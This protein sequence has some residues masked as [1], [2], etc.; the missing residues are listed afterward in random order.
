MK[1]QRILLIFMGN[2]GLIGILNQTLKQKLSNNISIS[3]KCL[4]SFTIKN[5]LNRI[6]SVNITN[7]KE[8]RKLRFVIQM[9]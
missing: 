2:T 7:H 5:F 6:F 3:R 4:S 8:Y 9:N 1:Q